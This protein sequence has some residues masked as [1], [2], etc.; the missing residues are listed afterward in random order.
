MDEALRIPTGTEAGTVMLSGPAEAA[1]SGSAG[2]AVYMA[3]PGYGGGTLNWLSPEREMTG[4]NHGSDIWC[5][6]LLSMWLANGGTHPWK[7]SA[8][9]WRPGP[10]YEALRE[11]FHARYADA[12]GNMRQWEDRGGFLCFLRFFRLSVAN[13]M[14]IDL[15]EATMGMLRHAYTQQPEQ[16]QWRLTAAEALALLGSGEAPLSVQQAAKRV[17]KY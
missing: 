17:R 11:R 5:A 15:A 14:C 9:P 12:L 13:L 6:G 2:T 7:L 3:S 16:R 8:N 1:G 10:V 4:L